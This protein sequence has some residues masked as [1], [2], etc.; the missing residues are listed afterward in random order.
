MKFSEI[1]FLVSNF[2]APEKCH[3]RRRLQNC[4]SLGALNAHSFAACGQYLK[5]AGHQRP[6][7]AGPVNTSVT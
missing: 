2:Q 5:K 6:D 3:E 4:Y 1:V 7:E